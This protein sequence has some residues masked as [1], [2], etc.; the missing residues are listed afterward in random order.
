MA[1]VN[2]SIPDELRQSMDGL[3]CNWS[4]IAQDAFAHTVAIETLKE[5]GRDMEAGLTRLKVDKHRHGE[6]EQA[7]GFQHGSTWALEDASYDELR[8]GAGLEREA[9]ETVEWVNRVLTATRFDLPGMGNA[10]VSSAYARGFLD[11]AAN[12]FSKV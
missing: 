12:V 10:S 11:G 5:E 9:K 1:R 3:N 6:R 4:A 8:E 2:L 7:E